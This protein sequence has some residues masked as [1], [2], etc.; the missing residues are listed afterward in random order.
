MMHYGFCR[1]HADQTGEGGCPECAMDHQQSTIKAMTETA[2]ENSRVHIEMH[3]QITD[4]QAEVARLLDLTLQPR[5][6]RE[7]S[8]MIENMS[9]RRTATE[10]ALRWAW[11][12]WK[13]T[14][15]PD[16]FITR[17]LAALLGEGK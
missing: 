5:N 11:E 13:P 7:Q 15:T 3:N 17:G 10:A 12:N 4:L 16:P 1:K 14:L 2:A 6:L 9:I 8:L